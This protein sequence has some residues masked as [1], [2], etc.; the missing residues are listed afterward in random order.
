[1]DFIPIQSIIISITKG[2]N[3]VKINLKLSRNKIDLYFI[4]LFYKIYFWLKVREVINEVNHK[5]EV[6]GY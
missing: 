6:V 5:M 1:M 2:K 4:I 3:T